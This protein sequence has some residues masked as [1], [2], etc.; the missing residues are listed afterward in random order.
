MKTKIF[1]LALFVICFVNNSLAQVNRKLE[2]NEGNS[3]PILSSKNVLKS[4]STTQTIEIPLDEKYIGDL[5]SI[6]IEKDGIDELVVLTNYD[7]ST[8]IGEI[9]I[10]KIISDS[11]S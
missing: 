1:Y 9:L 3:N 2:L 10:Y 7:G 4:V 8:Q 5:K 6:D 11:C